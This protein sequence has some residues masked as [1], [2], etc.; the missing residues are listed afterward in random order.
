MTALARPQGRGAGERRVNTSLSAD[1]LHSP[2]GHWSVAPAK[3]SLRADDEAN[4]LVVAMRM[5]LPASQRSVPSP[6][7]LI[8]PPVRGHDIGGVSQPPAVQD[9]ARATPGTGQPLAAATRTAFEPL[10]RHDFSQVR[11]HAGSRE[12][13]LLSARGASAC[14]VGS[15]LL[16]AHGQ[17]RPDAPHGRRLIAHELAHVVQQA[18]GRGAPG[19]ARE[20]EAGQAA[21]RAVNG[22]RAPVA[23]GTVTHGTPQF[24]DDDHTATTP[25]Q[26][27][28]RFENVWGKNLKE[29]ALAAALY[30]LAWQS[31]RHYAFV[32]EVFGALDAENQQQVA[33][34]FFKQLSSD[35]WLAELALTPSGRT[36]LTGI[37]NLLPTRDA[38]RRRA[39]KIVAAGPQNEREQERKQ[40][41]DRLKREGGNVDL[42]FYTHYEGM[43]MAEYLL[44]G[45]AE[46][47][48]K[49]KRT[50]AAFPMAAFD[51]IG[52]ALAF[53]AGRHQDATGFVRGLHLMGHGTED[54]FGFGEHYYSSAYLNKNYTS[55]QFAGYMA[56]GATVYLEG[57]DVAKGEA[58]KR[59]LQAV[60]RIF[61]GSE[62]AGFLKGNTCK[63]IGMGEMTECEPRTLRWPSD[64]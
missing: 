3:L 25:R 41:I 60:G 16:F 35:T 8:R 20:S 45:M 42:T 36:L 10:F 62:K 17:Y 19:M 4:G 22:M 50:D 61:F 23:A 40:A 1:R 26:F 21:E 47:R 52:A 11:V 32:L 28:E 14:T 58:G 48:V 6:G 34:A 24:K 29:G 13:A 18:G 9:S 33:T 53:I 57:C 56:D 27:I 5:Q 38:Q 15:D 43:D 46:G 59:Y 63:V 64:F 55:G 2:T 54:H 49:D 44:E 51:D 30:E 7:W 12:D 39:E 37:A 31:P